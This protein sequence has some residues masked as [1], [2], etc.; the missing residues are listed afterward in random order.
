MHACFFKQ[1]IDLFIIIID[2][3]N[4]SLYVGLQTKGKF[5][6]PFFWV[7][8][9]NL[10]FPKVEERRCLMSIGT[11]SLRII[12]IKLPKK[13]IQWEARYCIKTMENDTSPMEV[14]I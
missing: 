14:A 13:Y 3:D 4:S 6:C 12:G 8:R 7:L 2:I 10:V 9:S 5:A 11:S 1:S